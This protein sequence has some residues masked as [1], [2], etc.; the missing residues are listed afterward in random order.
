MLTP[1][2]R[3]IKTSDGS[4]TLFSDTMNESYHSVNGAIQESM[5]VFISNG[6]E[7]LISEES[8]NYP[9]NNISASESVVKTNSPINILEIGFGTGLNCLLTFIEAKKR[10]LCIKYQTIEAFPLSKEVTDSLNYGK[11]IDESFQNTFLSIHDC[12]WEEWTDIEDNSLNT[13]ELQQRETCSPELNLLAS[14]SEESSISYKRKHSCANHYAGHREISPIEFKL[15]K[16]N[17]DFT[18]YEHTSC[19]DL[20][21][22][23]AFAPNKQPELWEEHLFEKLFNAMNPGGI[24]VTYCAMGEVR[25][26]LQRSGF[27]TTRLPGPPGKREMLFAKKIV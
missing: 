14:G 20:V 17:T 12:N 21:Y 5:H 22:F 13:H 11:I 8:G 16:L 23:D 9:E 6:L 19:Y 24:L 15:K 1:D 27:T 26:R 18:K 3:L 4:D 2:F 7:K 25:R 10:N